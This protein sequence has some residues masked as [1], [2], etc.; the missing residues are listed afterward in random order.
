MHVCKVLVNLIMNKNNTLINMYLS[1]CHII[2]V[3]VH[4]DKYIY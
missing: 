2:T 4:L 1:L 3:V